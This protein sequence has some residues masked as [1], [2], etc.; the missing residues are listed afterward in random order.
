MPETR[1]ET[2]CQTCGR[3][4]FVED[5]DQDG[6]CEEHPKPKAAPSPTPTRVNAMK[7]A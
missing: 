6:N 2:T 7:D 3:A 1:R 4:M 5:V